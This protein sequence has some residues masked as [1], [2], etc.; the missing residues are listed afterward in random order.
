MAAP[1]PWLALTR[2]GVFRWLAVGV[3]LLGIATSAVAFSYVALGD[4][5]ATGAGDDMSGG[6]VGRYR[7]AAAADL[8]VSIA[9]DNL[10]VGGSTSA[11]LLAT[12][13]TDSGVRA[14]VAAAD[15]VTLD[16]GGDDLLIAIFAFKGGTCGGAD[17]QDCLRQAVA[18]FNGNWPAI[19]AALRALN[20]GA[21]IR[22]MTYY[23]PLVV[24]D[25]EPGDGTSAVARKYVPE[26]NDTIRGSA[27]QFG[28][29][30]AEG[31][32]AFN[33]ARGTDDPIAKGYVAADHIHPSPLGHQVLADAFRALGYSPAA[34]TFIRIPSSIALKDDAAPPVDAAKRRLSFAASTRKGTGPANRIVP[35]PAGGPQDPRTAGAVLTVYNAAGL[36]TDN[37]S[38]PL[39]ASGWSLDRS[40]GFRF[41]GTGPVRQAI[42]VLDRIKVKG[43]GAG[44]GYSLDEPSQGMVAVRLMLG[45]G[46]WCAVAGAKLSGSPPSTAKSDR[47]GKFVGEKN[48]PPPATCPPDGSPTTTTSTIVTTTTATSSTT[49][50]LLPACS[51]GVCGACGACGDGICLVQGGT[52]CAHLGSGTVCVSNS[53]CA[54][55]TCASDADC[56]PGEICDNVSGALTVCCATCP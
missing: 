11:A 22:T 29:A 30:V 9:L 41:K 32:L 17:G 5:L 35:P 20:P 21:M 8:G 43:G 18:G 34:G 26:L 52:T 49:T 23:N 33:G 16:I 7:D 36:T 42:I 56:A 38:V 6:Y 37:V 40:N 28:I 50:T 47:A 15:L 14:A 45:G 13:T 24:A 4:S 3:M 44:F 48:A 51:S 54:A 19:L 10:A 27:P 31:F 12:L 46:G 53:T 1:E 25:L 55:S 39:A 2:L